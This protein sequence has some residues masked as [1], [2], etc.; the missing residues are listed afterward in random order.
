MKTCPVCQRPYAD[1]AM[2][3]CLADGAELI[4]VSRRLDLDATWRF[5][6]TSA[7]PSAA[8]IPPTVAAPQTS[9]TL[10]QSTIQYRP[11]LQQALPQIVTSVAPTNRSVLPWIF[12]MVVVVAGSAILIV[13]ILT[14]GK[15]SPSVQLPS[16]T[17]QIAPSPAP[18]E[19]KTPDRPGATSSTSVNKPPKSA[20]TQSTVPAVKALINTEPHR[21]ETSKVPADKKVRKEE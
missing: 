14:Q 16:A 13:V 4:D 17:Q 19:S 8:R 2:V 12:G 3:Y 21:R 18:E 20:A 1:D 7:E 10:P 11:E 15:N 6:P 9:E 5:I